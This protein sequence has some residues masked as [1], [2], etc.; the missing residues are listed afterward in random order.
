MVVE[1]SDQKHILVEVAYA[2]PERQVIIPLQVE[3]G[4]TA[5]EAAKSSGIAVD[6]PE[7][8][9]A[10]AKMGIFGK[11]ITKPDEVVLQEKDRVEIYRPLIADPKEVRRKR[12]EKAKAEKQKQSQAG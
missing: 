2:R 6:F 9:L 8:D 1:N 10:K 4:C 7:I 3:P 12:A 5:L 11:L